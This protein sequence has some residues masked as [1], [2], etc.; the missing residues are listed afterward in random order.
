MIWL[1]IG[2]ITI[3]L[4]AALH[5]YVGEIRLLGPLLRKNDL[6]LLG[7]SMNYTRVIIRWAWHL[8]SLAWF[9]F[10]AIFLGLTQVAEIERRVPLLILTGFLALSGIIVLIVTR[11]RHPAWIFFLTAAFCAVIS[12]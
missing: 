8:T 9:G 6:P 5:S 3:S 12:T 4:L 2:S 11:G 1:M 7:D 10:G